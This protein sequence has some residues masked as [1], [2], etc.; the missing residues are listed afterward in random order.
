MKKALFILALMAVC[1]VAHA[2]LEKELITL[3]KPAISSTKLLTEAELIEVKE[4]LAGKILKDLTPTKNDYIDENN[5]G[6]VAFVADK[7]L[8]FAGK[9]RMS[10]SNYSRHKVV[11][12]DGSI[13]EDANFSQKEPFTEA[14]FGKNITFKNCNLVNVKIDA[15]W[16][17]QDSN[18]AQV[19]NE[20]EDVG[21]KK[22]NVI[23]VYRQKNDS[24]E[25]VSREEIISDDIVSK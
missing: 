18:T 12:P 17:I 21:G 5:K 16:I 23:K 14:V 20:I 1:G 9:Y 2:Q 13:V 15:S 10:I 25:E 3:E 22:F 4:Y 6:S 8:D 19:L 24:F 7:S 11:I